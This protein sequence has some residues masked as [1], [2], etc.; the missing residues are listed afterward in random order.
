[1]TELSGDVTVDCK[2]AFNV[3]LPLVKVMVVGENLFWLLGEN[4]DGFPP[5]AV[6]TTGNVNAP[7]PGVALSVGLEQLTVT[8][9]AAT[10]TLRLVDAVPEK[11]VLQLG[12]VQ[13]LY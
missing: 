5:V 2:V 11:L 8:G 9:E 13:T 6:Q 4:R 1:M 10:L 3:L 12:V 7:P